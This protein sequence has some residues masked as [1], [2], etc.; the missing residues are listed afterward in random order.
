MLAFGVKG[1]IKTTVLCGEGLWRWKM[2][3]FLENK[4]NDIIHELIQKTVLLTSV[5]DDKRKFRVTTSRNVFRDNEEVLFEAQLFN[6][7]YEMV[8]DPDVEMEIKDEE[9]N[10]YRFIFDKTSGNYTLNADLL[11]SG[12]YTYTAKTQFSGQLL[13]ARGK[14]NVESIQLENYDLTARHGL[15]KSISDKYNGDMYYPENM[16]NIKSAIQNNKA[17]KPVLYETKS[18]RTLLD[19]KWLFFLILGFLGAEWFMR[20]FLGSY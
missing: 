16:E 17:I 18:T 8:N 3:D 7:S 5:K 11:P 6:E 1:G 19:F 4:N 20:R 12:V 2:V 10:E 9:G 15:L 13:T 14:F